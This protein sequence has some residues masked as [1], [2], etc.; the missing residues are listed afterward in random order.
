M[1]GEFMLCFG[2]M[3]GISAITCMPSTAAYR[4]WRSQ[5]FSRPPKIVSAIGTGINQASAVFLTRRYCRQLVRAT[6]ISN[7]HRCLVVFKALQACLARSK[8]GADEFFD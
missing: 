8:L 6:Q 3:N 1:N 2:R 4:H 7:A 5:E